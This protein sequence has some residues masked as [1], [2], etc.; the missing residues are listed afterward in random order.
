MSKTTL[1]GRRFLIKSMKVTNITWSVY[2]EDIWDRLVMVPDEV[3]ADVIEHNFE[4]WNGLPMEQKHD[5]LLS[6]LHHCPAKLNMFMELPDEL[7][8]PDELVEDDDICD[9][10]CDKY[11]F[12]IEGFTLE[13]DYEEPMRH[14]I[15]TNSCKH[16]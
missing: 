16:F 3:L 7:E 8:V 1:K 13:S 6:L 11:G 4:K 9:Y 10:M 14:V 15:S 12:L 5:Y 2:E